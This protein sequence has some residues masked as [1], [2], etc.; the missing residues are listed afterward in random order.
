MPLKK[1]RTVYSNPVAE[2][3]IQNAKYIK[4][5]TEIFLG[6]RK[7]DVLRGFDIF[8]NF[9][10]FDETKRAPGDEKIRNF[11]DKKGPGA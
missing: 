10:N 8:V 6:K 5:C 3:P 11:D 7:I 9:R 2:L 1:K 4:N